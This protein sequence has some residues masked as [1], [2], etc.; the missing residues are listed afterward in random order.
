[1]AAA[2]PPPEIRVFAQLPLNP[3]L[4]PQV[5]V[6]AANWRWVHCLTIPVE[7]FNALQFSRRPY[8]WIRYAI[9]VVVG[10]E[11]VLSTSPDSHNPVEDS[12][13][14][15]L[16]AASADLHY[17]ISDEEKRRMFPAD[18]RI[19]HT[20]ITSDVSTS[21]RTGFRREVV[22]RD[23]DHCIL[24]GYETCEAVHLLPHSK[25]DTVC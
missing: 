21:R 15:L 22:R 18:P 12:T 25:G 1:M 10:A 24:T 8:K 11:G 16:P 14:V 17:R 7:K 20:R 6:Q 4:N 2:R 5:L 23:G 3:E 13:V 9:G 19:G